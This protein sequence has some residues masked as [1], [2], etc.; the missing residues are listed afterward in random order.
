MSNRASDIKAISPSP[1]PLSVRIKIK[2]MELNKHSYVWFILFFAFL[3]LYVMLNISF[4]D[5]TQFVTN[6]WLPSFPLHWEN[7]AMGWQVVKG[8]IAN[9]VVVTVTATAASLFIGTLAA[10]F[11]AR[12]RMP[13]SRL[14]WSL[15]M[16]LLLM[17]MVANLL[18]LF[19]LMKSLHLLN[20]LWLLIVLGT[21]S[22]QII[23]IYIMRG[24][25][26]DIP[27]DLFESAEID[28]ATHMQQIRHIVLPL[29]GSIL[30]TLAIL[31]F[32]G[33]WNE[34]ILPL[35]MIRDQRLQTIAVGLARLDAE[36][37]KQWGVTMAAFS[38]S[39]I[40]LILL[41]IFTMRLFVRG[42]SAGALKG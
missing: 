3:P 32:I 19:K 20:S 16:V 33:R 27:R 22:G 38:I 41:F 1:K 4:K 11:F 13:L 30:S 40:P 24:F 36:Y 39:S 29:S 31:N 18:P 34:F 7:W 12:Y 15:F 6:P 5:N 17:P 14:L 21:T 37:V 35:V 8:Y 10:Y 2:L 23:V 26:E 25:I 28:G 9:T 42:L